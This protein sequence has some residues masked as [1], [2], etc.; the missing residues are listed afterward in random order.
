MISKLTYIVSFFIFS[1]FSCAETSKYGLPVEEP[2]VILKS[3]GNF[4][5]YYNTYLK[6][7][8][9]F[10]GLDSSSKIIERGV[11]LQYI[12]SGKYLPLRLISKDSVYFKLYKINTSVDNI[13]T[14][15]LQS[16]GVTEYK[17]FQMEGKPLPFFNYVDLNDNVYNRETTKRKIVVLKFWFIHCAPCVKEFPALNKLVDTYV[18]RKDILFLSLAFDQ[19]SDLV[20][21]L[22]K[23]KFNYAVI[24]NQKKYL[25]EDLGMTLFPTHIVINKNGD[26]VKV[27]NT[28]EEL[29][30]ILK[31]EALN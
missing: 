27:V 4:L 31:K 6:L 19:K 12:S 5:R 18:K 2:E 30:P 16:S 15:L 24:A 20:N 9:N 10:I 25:L 26:V 11:F 13:I 8:E 22:E 28:Y 23:N 3:Q 21:F 29:E 7:S 14:V 1:L 17:Y